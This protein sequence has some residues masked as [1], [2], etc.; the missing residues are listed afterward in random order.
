M[1][2]ACSH[3]RQINSAAANYCRNCGARFVRPKPC[4]T[5]CGGRSAAGILLLVFVVFGFS[6]F[7]LERAIR[8]ILPASWSGAD[9][10]PQTQR[11]DLQA[12]QADAMYALLAPDDVRVVVGRVDH[13]RISVRGTAREI[14][15]LG[16]FVSLMRRANRRPSERESPLNRPCTKAYSLTKARASRLARILDL[17][18]IPFDLTEGGRRLVVRAAPADQETIAQ[19]V[20]IIE[21]E[22]LR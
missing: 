9:R 21:G 1:T 5:G 12:A 15:V 7:P 3:C 6:R 2:K 16:D 18:P 11:F 10:G 17:G 20:R 4:R 8:R 14:A 13:G 22:R 19:V